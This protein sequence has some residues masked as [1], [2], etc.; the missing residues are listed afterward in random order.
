MS[1]TAGGNTE[2][3]DFFSSSDTAKGY[4]WWLLL[5]HGVEVVDAYFVFWPNG[6]LTHSLSYLCAKEK[7]LWPSS[8][9]SRIE[10]SLCWSRLVLK[11]VSI[12]E[13]SLDWSGLLGC[14]VAVACLLKLVVW[15]CGCTSLCPRGRWLTA[16]LKAWLILKMFSFDW[17]PKTSLI[18][19]A[20]KTFILLCYLICH[21]CTL[22]SSNRMLGCYR[23]NL[24]A[25]S[26]FCTNLWTYL[27]ILLKGLNFLALD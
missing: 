2:L 9:K 26:I 20:D 7:L 22:C 3:T 25:L 18:V 17:L 21:T 12:D 4:V 24:E 27:E 14:N 15:L 23:V 6:L 1:Q 16:L 19:H 8:V 11:Q 5:Y 10:L 13:I